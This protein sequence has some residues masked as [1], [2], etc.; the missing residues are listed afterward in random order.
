MI[1]E[2][3][4][5]K[6]VFKLKEE[7]KLTRKNQKTKVVFHD[8]SFTRV[9]IESI[10]KILL[11]FQDDEKILKI[12]E[13]LEPIDKFDPYEREKSDNYDNVEKI[14]I[15]LDERFDAWYEKYL[16]GLKT[17]LTNLGYINML[18]VYDVVLDINEQIQLTNKSMIHIPLIPPLIRFQ[19]LFPADTTGF[20]DQYCQNRLSSLK[21]LKSKNVINEFTHGRNGWDTIVEISLKV[22]NFDEFYQEAKSNYKDRKLSNKK[23]KE[24]KVASKLT[25]SK[26]TDW[27]KDFIWENG[28]FVL[29]QYGK[30]GFKSADRKHIFKTLTGKKGGWAKV[31]EMRGGK[32]AGYVRSTIKQIKDRLP[33]K[34]KKHVVIVSTQEDDSTDKPRVGAYKIKILS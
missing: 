6:I 13:V 9:R 23:T 29:G 4:L 24:V 34:A 26:Q 21:Y 30:I 2:E 12:I 25:S 32:S 3:K 16:M 27:P 28:E 18:R 8:G 20:R 31:S 33:E 15:E 7:R 22:S 11:Q 14:T 19:A 1:Y 10:C 5:A 17:K